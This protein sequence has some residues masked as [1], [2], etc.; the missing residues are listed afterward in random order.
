MSWI[1]SRYDAMRITLR[2]VR[3]ASAVASSNARAAASS[4]SST[5]KSLEAARAR[6]QA[7]KDACKEDKEKL[8]EWDLVFKA[9]SSN[10]QVA[11]STG[12][13]AVERAEKLEGEVA[14]LEGEVLES[15]SATGATLTN[16]L[17]WQVTSS[18]QRQSRS[19]G[20]LPGMQAQ[21]SSVRGGRR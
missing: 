21:R 3:L 19:S 9:L 18:R 10:L 17:V 6:I 11:R 14:R 8:R 4:N 7:L 16:V 13:Q 2:E 1:R 12:E 15:E 20:D 5:S